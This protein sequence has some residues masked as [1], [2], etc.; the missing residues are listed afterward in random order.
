M[1]IIAKVISFILHPLIMP[2]IGLLFIYSSDLSIS[3]FSPD[4]KRAIFLL[5]FLSTFVIP[6]GFIPLIMLNKREFHI[7]MTSARDRLLPFFLTAVTYFMAFY[8]LKKA[9][10]PSFLLYFIFGSGV[11]VLLATIITFFWKISIHMIGIGGIMGLLFFLSVNFH[12][13]V[14]LMSILTVLLSGVIG[15]SRLALQV[16]TPSQIYAGFVIGL[17]TVMTCLFVLS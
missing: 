2:T 6:L 17:T 9:G 8:F 1:R 7:E 14:F 16:H 5:I 13:D 4:Q 10:L 15:T 12:A 3:F 11:A